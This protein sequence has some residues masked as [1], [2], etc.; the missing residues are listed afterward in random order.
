MQYKL[1]L[2]Q[3]LG[4]IQHSQKW[5]WKMLVAQH[6]IMLVVWHSPTFGLQ[7]L[8]FTNIN[9]K[10]L[11]IWRKWIPCRLPSTA[12]KNTIEF[13]FSE[14][15]KKFMYVNLL[16]KNLMVQTPSNS[17]L[18]CR[19][20]EFLKKIPNKCLYSLTSLHIMLWNDTT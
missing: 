10:L 14:C 15:A 5:K 18:I 4:N 7:V 20:Y 12:H 8:V 11:K 16:S 2:L 19:K 1:P 13:F 6:S 9:T 17:D 3:V